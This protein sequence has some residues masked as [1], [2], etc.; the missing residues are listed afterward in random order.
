VKTGG[1]P[2]FASFRFDHSEA[3]ALRTLYTQ[4]MLDRGFLGT[5]GLY[6]TLAH[7][8]AIVDLY[9]EAIDSV[10]KEIAEVL[11]STDELS[12]HL[13]GPVAHSGFRRLAG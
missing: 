10:F 12:A 9:A 2:C 5:A 4:M 8:E 7:T 6:P 3:D 1:L 13:H 11:A